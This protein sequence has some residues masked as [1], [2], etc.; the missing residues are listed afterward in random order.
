MKGISVAAMDNNL[1]AII[2]DGQITVMVDDD[3]LWAKVIVTKPNGGRAVTYDDVMKEL[4]N[5]GVTAHINEQ[6]V[7]ES[8]DYAGEHLSGVVVAEAV[9]PVNGLDGEVNYSYDTKTE[10][11]PTIDEETGIVNFRELGRVRNIR[12]GA[13]I[14]TIKANTMGTP[15]NDVRGNEIK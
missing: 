6:A 5:N 3:Y 12:K 2:L 4:R 9:P 14:A 10:F 7:K 8:V 15:G 13:L 11:K 1:D